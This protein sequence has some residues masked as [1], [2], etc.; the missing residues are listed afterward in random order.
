[1]FS[2]KGLLATAT[3]QS[4]LISQADPTRNAV[5][6]HLRDSV[7]A[8]TPCKDDSVEEESFFNNDSPVSE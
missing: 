2:R 5:R 3:P 4:D 8:S 6:T 7:L 1:M